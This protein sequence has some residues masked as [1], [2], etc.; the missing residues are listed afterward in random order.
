MV[1]PPFEISDNIINVVC[2]ITNKLGKLE[3]S[4]D[5]KKS[6]F[7]TKTS[8]IKSVCFSCAIESNTLTEQQV[9][10]IINGKMI[11]APPNEILE[12]TNAYGAYLI[13]QGFKAY[14]IK[15]FLE[16][17]K[18]FTAHL[19]SDAGKLRTG[20]VAASENEKLARAG[21]QPRFI[22]DLMNDLLNWASV[23]DMNPLIKACI[24]HY[25][26]RTIHPFTDGNGRVARLW[27]SVV[28]YNYNKIFELIPIEALIYENQWRYYESIEASRRN[29][30]ARKF[31]EFMLE[32]IS[33]AIDS[34]N[35]EKDESREIK[36]EYL[37]RLT[38]YEKEILEIITHNFDNDDYFS[39]EKLSQKTN[40]SNSGIR[41][42]LKKLKS[43][44]ILFTVGENRGRKYK[45]NDDIF[46]Q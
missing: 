33:K 29:N 10:G 31:I 4:F 44:E 40:K 22:Y 9:E 12:V 19:L 21:A 5:M 8:K 37:K 18:A 43:E 46:L 3:V 41:N 20:E 28:L 13:I 25:E 11:A 7:L 6:L 32:M 30:S 26:I 27:Q 23:S 34:F 16:A 15:S 45:V 35:S 36:D 42:N 17:H 24:M 39:M 38:K 2:D 1:K 14:K